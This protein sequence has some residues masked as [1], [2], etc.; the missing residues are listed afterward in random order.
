MW[1]NHEDKEGDTHNNE[2]KKNKM[3]GVINTQ[4]KSNP[5]INQ[6]FVLFFEL[7]YFV[8]LVIIGKTYDKIDTIIVK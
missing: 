5:E 7:E 2:D 1:P 3:Y 6:K 8:W 4:D